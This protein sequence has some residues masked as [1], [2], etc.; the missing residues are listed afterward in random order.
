LGV[1]IV[2]FT[3]TATTAHITTS[4][5]SAVSF[6][7]VPLAGLSI[8]R[9]FTVQSFLEVLNPGVDLSLGV[10]KALADILANDGKI[11]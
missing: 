1:R 7:S 6:L 11:I 5:R 4:P 10:Q 9:L 8:L 2:A 3:V